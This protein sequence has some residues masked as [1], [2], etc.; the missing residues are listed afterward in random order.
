MEL[1]S[2]LFICLNRYKFVKATQSS[3]KI[4]EPFEFDQHVYLDRYIYSN[5]EAVKLKRK[6]LHLLNA[7]LAKLEAKLNSIKN[8]ESP[9]S[10][11]QANKY[12]LD[13]ILKC[14]LGFV[15]ADHSLNEVFNSI[16]PA[17]S[18]N[19]DHVTEAEKVA[20]VKDCL[21]SW[22]AKVEGK[23]RELTESISDVKSKIENIFDVPELKRV[24]YN[25]HSVCIHEGNAI[26]GHFWTYIWNTQQLKW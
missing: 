7:S 11:K 19:E 12:A 15:A 25:L 17:V 10:T 1:P 4:L 3:A 14:A 23:I 2:V 20:V 13:D 22:I 21:T 24:K 26:S 16:I 6:E 5:R 18:T 9:E 8:Y